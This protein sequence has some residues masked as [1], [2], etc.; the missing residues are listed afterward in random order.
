MGNDNTPEMWW[1]SVYPFAVQLE[2]CITPSPEN[3]TN[4]DATEIIRVLQDIGFNIEQQRYSDDVRI[5]REHLL[6]AVE[7][8]V[9]AYEEKLRGQETEVEYHYSSGLMQIAQFHHILVLHGFAS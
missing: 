1:Q 5:M 3:Y 2:K 6:R 9:L 4:A 7:Y 8:L